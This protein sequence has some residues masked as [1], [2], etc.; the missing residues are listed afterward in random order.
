TA[1]SMTGSPAPLEA[2]PAQSVSMGRTSL[3][4]GAIRCDATSVRNGSEVATVSRRQRWTLVRSGS[5]C[6]REGARGEGT[7]GSGSASCGHA[8]QQGE[9]PPGRGRRNGGDE[10]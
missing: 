10:D 7:P 4:P 9:E 6:S 3:P 8:T 5:R 2:Y 1:S